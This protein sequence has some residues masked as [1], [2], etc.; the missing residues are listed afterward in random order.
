MRIT[1]NLTYERYIN[2]LM[3]RQ[4]DIYRINKQISTGKRVNAASDDPVSAN[5][6][7]T[8]KSLLASFGQY[9]N[10]IDYGVS[11]LG[12]TETALD[13]VKNVLTRLQ[14]LAVS[15]ASGMANNDTRSFIKS[16]VDALRDELISI[17]NTN[18][19]G[20]YIFSGYE[21]DTPAFDASG[22]YQGDTNAQAI[23]ISAASTL[24]LGIN[25]GEVFKGAGGGLDILTAVSDF[26]TA[27]AANDQAGV[28]TAI[29][30]LDTAFTQ[31]STAVS[32]IGGRVSR[33]NAAKDDYS[34]YSLELKMTISSLED[35][36]ITHLISD[37]KISQVALEAAL[38]SAGQ[39]FKMNIFNYL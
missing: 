36:D 11:Y 20:K 37:L 10:N 31:V 33:L 19:D 12:I 5:D 9:S 15:A 13:R 14:E 2:D 18:F 24:T 28:Q 25:G 3:R 23:K 21:T 6:I 17:G 16:E 4:E 29:G 1:Q 27:L 7:L 38:A 22:N 34:S 8:S 30:N 39:V 35:A 32:D 26:S